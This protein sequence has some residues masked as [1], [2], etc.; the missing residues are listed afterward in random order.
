MWCLRAPVALLRIVLPPQ[1]VRSPFTS[2]RRAPGRRALL[3]QQQREPRRALAEQLRRGQPVSARAL[4]AM[5]ASAGAYD[6]E[7][8]AACK[9]VRL[10]A[11]LCTVSSR[12]CPL[13][14]PSSLDSYLHAGN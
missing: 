13:D 3:Q 7:L 9:A 6:S 8:D 14:K 10:A 4:C 1:C 5:A 11:V 2:A 12:C